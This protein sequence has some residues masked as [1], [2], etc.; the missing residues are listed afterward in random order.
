[1]EKKK[2]MIEVNPRTAVLVI[3][4]LKSVLPDV[5][6]QMAEQLKKNGA[7]IQLK[8]EKPMQDVLEEIYKKCAEQTDIKEVTRSL[9][10]DEG[11]E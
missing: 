8:Y 10:L 7:K 5:V 11:G 4:L 2:I 3:G 9:M 1:M 6:E